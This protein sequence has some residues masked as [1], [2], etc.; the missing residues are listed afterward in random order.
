M[1]IYLFIE[2]LFIIQSL[3]VWCTV[4]HFVGFLLFVIIAT[5][6]PALLA[7]DSGSAIAHADRSRGRN[8][9]WR[10]TE[11][12]TDPPYPCPSEVRPSRKEPPGEDAPTM[13]VVRDIQRYGSNAGI[14]RD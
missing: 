5:T 7:T 6:S 4:I 2:E 8:N 13:W 1:I 14:D 12:W 11:D 9:L 10:Q 3:C